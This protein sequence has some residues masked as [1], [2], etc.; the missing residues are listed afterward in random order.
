MTPDLTTRE[1]EVVVAQGTEITQ[2]QLAAAVTE[3]GFEL[4]EAEFSE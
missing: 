3:A 1:V 2:E 4:T